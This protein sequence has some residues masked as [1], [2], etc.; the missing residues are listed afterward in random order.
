MFEVAVDLSNVVRDKRLAPVGV[1]ASMERFNSL[2]EALSGPNWGLASVLAVADD[3]L[4]RVLDP[5]GARALRGL[6]A[7]GHAESLEVAD[8]RLLELAVAGEGM[9]VATNDK[10]ADFRRRYPEIESWS[11]RFIG[12]DADDKTGQI[13]PFFR[14]M[15]H[16]DNRRLS[17]KEE[18]KEL[19]QARLENDDVLAQALKSWFRCEKSS[20]LTGSYYPDRIPMLPVY[21]S[22]VERFVCP[23]CGST[24]AEVGERAPATQVVVM[25]NGEEISRILLEEGTS[26]GLGRTAAR[27]IIGIDRWV[28]AEEVRQLSRSHLELRMEAGRVMVRDVGTRNG[29]LL[30]IRHS[31]GAAERLNDVF[32]VVDVRHRVELPSGVSLELSARRAVAEGEQAESDPVPSSEQVAMTIAQPWEPTE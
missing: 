26:L 20:C 17:R 2:L 4:F 18:S 22:R 14:D 19:R 31:S 9:L 25:H 28:E 32:R 24:L 11:D 29:S 21:D 7:D 16:M 10:L 27:N 13:Q 12:W 3:S 30:R 1:D 6:I 8:G 23:G 15:G 5:A